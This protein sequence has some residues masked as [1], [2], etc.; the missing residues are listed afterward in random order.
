[1]LGP[2]HRYPDDE[3]AYHQMR[4]LRS[5]RPYYEAHIKPKQPDR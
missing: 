1:V 2:E 3:L 5:M 4:A